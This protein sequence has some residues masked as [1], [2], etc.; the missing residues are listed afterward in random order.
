MNG[1]IEHAVSMTFL[2]TEHDDKCVEIAVDFLVDRWPDLQLTRGAPR[3][4]RKGPFVEVTVYFQ[5]ETEWRPE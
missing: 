2:S 4:D 5:S 1:E 3:V